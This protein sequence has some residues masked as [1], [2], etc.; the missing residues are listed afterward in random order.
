MDSI[1]SGPIP[2]YIISYVEIETNPHKY[3]HISGSINRE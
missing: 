1:V 3:K 2:K